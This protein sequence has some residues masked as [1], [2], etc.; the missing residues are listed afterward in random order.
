MESVVDHARKGFAQSFQDHS[1]ENCQI[2]T[3]QLRFPPPVEAQCRLALMTLEEHAEKNLRNEFA[4]GVKPW[5]RGD[6]LDITWNNITLGHIIKGVLH[7]DEQ[8]LV[9]TTIQDAYFSTPVLAMLE[10]DPEKTDFNLEKLS[11]A[12]LMEEQNCSIELAEEVG[13]LP[14]D[15]LKAFHDVVDGCKLITCVSQPA[16]G[17]FSISYKRMVSI[18]SD[19]ET[20]TSLDAEDD[21]HISQK[22]LSF[23]RA[24]LRVKPWRRMI[25]RYITEGIHDDEISPDYWSLVGKL[26]QKKGVTFEIFKEVSSAMSKWSQDSETPAREGGLTLLANKAV[27]LMKRL[28]QDKDEK[29]LGSIPADQRDR[30]LDCLKSVKNHIDEN[31]AWVKEIIRIMS[32]QVERDKGEKNV[33]TVVKF[34]SSWDG[35]QQPK[36]LEDAIVGLAD[37]EI[38]P[39]A[40]NTIVD[41]RLRAWSHCAKVLEETA[42][43]LENQFDE[44][45]ELGHYVLRAVAKLGATSMKDRELKRPMPNTLYPRYIKALKMAYKLKGLLSELLS[46]DGESS[47]DVSKVGKHILVCVDELKAFD[48]M[49]K[50]SADYTAFESLQTHMAPEIERFQATLVKLFLQ[51]G[52]EETKIL[53]KYSD[54]LQ[55]VHGG[56]DAG[57]QWFACV[58]KTALLDDADFKTQ[59]EYLS[60]HC[61]AQAIETRIVE[62]TEVAILHDVVCAV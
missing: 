4:A 60:R 45:L 43:L 11:T 18:F 40:V 19:A 52:E 32:T 12:I 31:N 51:V 23:A 41:C 53:E 13:K 1:N 9:A 6:E 21:D 15:I 10:E 5:V 28:L 14:V 36:T 2:I 56:D 39:A 42:S 3:K 37:S 8:A 25:Q 46:M 24:M 47:L 50:H 38:S 59:R 30:V 44:Q 48:L 22:V 54:R 34:C 55:R 33:E 16:P 20:G 57:H 61:C 35:T 62:V 58:P 17:M 7:E 26:A 49:V 27:D 29:A